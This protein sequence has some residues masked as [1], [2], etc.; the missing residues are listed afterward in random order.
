MPDQKHD[1][2]KQFKLKNFKSSIFDYIK[3]RWMKRWIGKTKQAK[4]KSIG[5]GHKIILT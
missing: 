2:S 5:T 1:G 4:I 3:Q